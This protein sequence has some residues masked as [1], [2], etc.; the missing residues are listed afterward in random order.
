MESKA[1]AAPV[2]QANI[3]IAPR[4]SLTPTNTKDSR[5]SK[6]EDDDWEV[7]GKSGNKSRP[8]TSSKPQEDLAVHFYSNFIL[9]FSF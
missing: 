1:P 9:T 8:P 6:Y 4:G 2:K 3:R 7:V 5:T